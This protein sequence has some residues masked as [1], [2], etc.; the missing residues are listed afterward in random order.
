MRERRLRI[1]HV[2]IGLGRGGAEAM[3]HK[4]VQTLDPGAGFVHSIVSLT[5]SNRFDYGSLGIPVRTLGMSRRVSSARKL[6]RLRPIVAAERPDLVQGWMYHG[7][8]AATLGTKSSVPVVW[9]IRHSVHDVRREKFLTRSILHI[10]ARLSRGSNQLVYCS[11]VSR[12]QHEALGYSAESSVV[13]PN[14]FDC[15]R[16]RPDPSRSGALREALGLPADAVLVGNAA[17]FHPM[18]NHLGLI[19]AFAMVAA[20]RPDVHLIM[21]GRRIDRDN[22][23]LLAAVDQHQLG[24]RV[25]LIGESESLHDLLPAFDIYVSASSWGEAFPNVLGEAMACGVPCATTDVGDSALIVADTGRV[26]PPGDVHAMAAAIDEMVSL[27]DVERSRLGA[28]ARMRIQNEF[29]LEKVGSH[30]AAMY[31]RIASGAEGRL[32]AR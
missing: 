1:V 20:N 14:G 24:G 25:H 12:D 30:Y 31:R 3:L 23:V 2:I 26:A 10:G 15:E 13:I 29:R 8:I 19:R 7:N 27:T 17:R 28:S 18:K 32:R 16:F 6:S 4:L 21:T 11:H 22:P 5:A 9:N